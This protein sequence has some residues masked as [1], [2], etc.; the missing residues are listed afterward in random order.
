MKFPVTIG[1]D[2]DGV[3]IVECPS[4]PGCVS[5]GSSKEEAIANIRD[6]IKSCLEAHSERGVPLIVESCQ[7]EITSDQDELERLA[8]SPKFQELLDRVRRQIEQ[9]GGIPHDAFWRDMKANNEHP[10]DLPPRS[11]DINSE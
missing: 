8:H 6:A 7:V 9:T 5:Q 2:E 4:L 10:G 3:W 11:S 1:R